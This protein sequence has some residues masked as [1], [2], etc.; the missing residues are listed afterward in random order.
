VIPKARLYQ[1][2]DGITDGAHSLET[3]TES[4]RAERR[5]NRRT[6]NGRLWK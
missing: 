1:A 3:G 5:R 2:L 4:Y 6:N